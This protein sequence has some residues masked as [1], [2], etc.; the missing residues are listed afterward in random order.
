MQKISQYALQIVLIALLSAHSSLFA[1]SLPDLGSDYRA[2]LSVSEEKMIGE[3]W[4]QQIRA[5]GMVY[6]DPL[7]NEYV[8][9][10][11]NKLTP[12]V[13]MPYSNLHVK[14]FAVNDKTINAFAFFGGHIAVHSGLILVT[15]SESE[16]A[17]VMSHELA[18][19]AQ[20]HILRQITES[21]NMLPLTVAGSLAAILLGVPDLIIPVIAGHGQHMI[22]FSRQHEQEADRIGIQILAQA[23]FDPQGLPNIFERMGLSLRYQSKPPEYLLS[24][25]VYESRIADTR[26][27]ANSFSYKQKSDSNMYNLVKARLEVQSTDNIQQLVSDYEHK[28][29]TKRHGNQI[30]INYA[31]AYAL[32]QA[33]KTN[34]ASNA[35]AALIK[36]Y[37]DDLIIQMT[38]ADIEQ[39]AQKY[40][41]AQ[42]RLEKLILLYPDSSSLAIQYTELL[43]QTK[44]PAAAKKVLQR[45]KAQHALEPIYYELARHADGMLG[46]QTAVYESNAEWYL[47]NGD[48]G[49]ALLQL[50]LALAAKGNEQ[51][52]DTRIKSR[53]ADVKELMK[54][55]KNI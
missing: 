3:S 10:I 40:P 20:Q 17:G 16:L 38:A 55:A 37:P 26:H 2:T 21:Q 50:D 34:A 27:R 31:Y 43:L 51:K 6:Y 49:S 18:H 24:H 30:Y 53:I 5:A 14:F 23:K 47:L 46:N 54:N 45:Y 19:V 52:T 7:I 48:L 42:S 32:L 15:Q 25:P 4:M 35:L 29:K 12:F 13:Q 41:A 11:G 33:G 39:T 28:L 9:Y 1:S 8:Q 36:E 44:Q 22:N